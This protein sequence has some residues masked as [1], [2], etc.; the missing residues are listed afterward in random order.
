MKH[1]A[2]T[3][4]TVLF[5]AAFVL[6]PAQSNRGEVQFYVFSATG[7]PLEGVTVEAEGS[8]YRSNADGFI[9][10]A[11]APGTHRF[12]LEQEGRAVAIVDVP[13]RQAEATEVIVTASENP[14]VQERRELEEEIAAENRAELDTTGPLGTLTGTVVALDSGEVIPRATIIFRGVDF[15][16]TTDDQGR[17]SADLPAGTY[18][19][20]VIHPDYSSRTV[21]DVVVEAEAAAAVDV[22]LTPAAIQLEEVAV[23]ATEEVI[24]Q[25]G[26]AN[27]I[28][29]T[30]NSAVVLNLI[31]A[32][33]IGRT[34]DSDA[35]GALSRVTG[36]TVNDQGFVYVRGMGERYSSSLL[37]T[38]R[39]P[40]PE[41]DRR[42]VPLDLFPASV[43]ESISVQKTFSPELPGDFGGGA[44]SIRT[45]GIPDDRYQRRLRTKV[46]ASVGYNVGTSLTEQLVAQR[47]G[48]D[49]LG[50]DLGERA[51]PE[52]IVDSGSIEVD[53]GGIFGTGGY[54]QEEVNEL[55]RS[56]PN[57][58]QPEE[59]KLPLDYGVNAS[60]RDKIELAGGGSFG[61]NIA[62]LYSNSWNNETGQLNSYQPATGGGV[63]AY[64][65]Y[66]TESTQNAIDLGSLLDLVWEPRRG[67]SVESTTL[68]VRSTT[69]SHEVLE[70]TTRDE[71]DLDVLLTEM[72]WT[73]DM[74][75]SQGVATEIATDF[76]QGITFGG[77]YV[78]SLAE[79]Y[80]PDAI[81]L[82]YLET[83][84][85]QAGDGVVDNDFSVLSQRRD[86]DQQRVWTTVRDTVHD[87]ELSMEIPLGLLGRP[88]SDYLDLGVYG[89]LQNRET[90]LRR[91]SF[92]PEG[93]DPLFEEDPGVVFDPANIGDEIT[94]LEGTYPAD[95]YTGEH[96]IGAGYAAVDTLLF[97][98]IRMNAGARAE[99]SRQSVTAF[100]FP[101]G[102]PE[103]PELETLDVLPAI[104]FT[105]PVLERSQIRFGGSRTVNRPDLRELS[106]APF[107][108]PPGFGVVQG[109]PDLK[110]AEIWNADLRWE[111]YLSMNESVSVGLFYKSFTDPIEIAQLQGAA[112]TK[113]PVNIDGATNIGVELE[114]AFQF[115]F[116]SDGL[117]SLM[118]S[119]DYATAE[120]ERQW[121]RRLGTVASVFRDL[122]ATGNV[123]LIQSR[124]D[125]GE[126]G[127]QYQGVTISNTSKER[128]LQ[129][130]APYVVNAALGY[131]NEVSWSQDRPIHTSAYLN[132]NVVGP[133]IFQLGVEG[134][135]DFYQQ[136]FHKLDL[137]LRQQ[138]GY[139]FSM[140]L[141][142]GNLLDLPVTQ[143][144]GRDGDGEII[145]EARRGRSVTLSVSFD[146]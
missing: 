65:T 30:R 91:F 43:I 103:T 16:T 77:R 6:V 27:L 33:Q 53:P 117:R 18:S 7:L 11:H 120:R 86:D 80:Q 4:A 105:V 113:V 122:R 110:R 106:S 89:M 50:I 127:L 118:L 145:S 84:G 20:S 38:A 35:A 82:Y 98:D 95:N 49:V 81:Y 45:A 36:L 116:V 112:F 66:T 79:R 56:L 146:Y 70:G 68:L 111:S 78:F 83:S 15:E 74:L 90:D 134:V 109:N 130:Q 96:L 76:L 17:F 132:Y 67:R 141:E 88:G 29:E 59:R 72:V 85:G 25:G 32:E 39:L 100:T 108:G 101:E 62:A 28:D 47:A 10:F 44:I 140:G 104:N 57:R 123:A 12:V 26:I 60:V 19:F 58:W 23:F 51:L 94:F 13:V 41:P 46:G 63:S 64:N 144:V 24:I 31:G 3:I 119:I 129:G 34:G 138:F 142:L 99:Y 21:D 131:R 55:G 124:V 61:F 143:T 114:W 136:P 42:V 69:D 75:F 5:F 126:S 139:I 40:S 37:N 125:Y 135:D 92:I 22:E 87:A 137:V 48:T 128:P 97:A 8:V 9:N 1:N 93:I 71:G 121:R 73:E 2:L 14:V 107:F 102:N 133:F 54:T 52:T 115:R